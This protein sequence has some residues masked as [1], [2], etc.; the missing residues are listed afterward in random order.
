MRSD[1]DCIV[2][3]VPHEEFRRLTWTDQKLFF[4]A[5]GPRLMIDVKRIFSKED[6]AAE[7]YQYWSL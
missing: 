3:L 6:A 4:R 7:N 1:A 5:D 2:Y